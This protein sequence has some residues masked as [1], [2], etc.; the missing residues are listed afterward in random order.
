MSAAPRVDMG[1]ETVSFQKEWTED[2]STE[3]MSAAPR[4]EMGPETVSFK[5]N[6][7]KTS[8]QREYQLRPE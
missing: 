6:G 1:P 3:T 7:Q 4:V 2:F 8:A 5:K